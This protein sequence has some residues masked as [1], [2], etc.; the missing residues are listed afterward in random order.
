MSHAKV[1]KSLRDK[2]FRHTWQRIKGGF[3]TPAVDCLLAEIQSSISKI[4]QLTKGS[5]AV[6]PK[7]VALQMRTSSRYWLQ[8]KEHARRLF[9]TLGSHWSCACPQLH[10]ASLRLDI[11]QSAS[12]REEED[13]KFNVLFSYDTESLNSAPAPLPWNWRELDIQ[14][15]PSKDQQ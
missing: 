10:R 6:A 3:D 7:R 15:M 1:D 13:Y 14:P 2:F 9:K 5:I 12:A 11:R 4:A 8:T